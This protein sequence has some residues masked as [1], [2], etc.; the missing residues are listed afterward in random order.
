MLRVKK[1]QWK[2]CVFEHKLTSNQSNRIDVINVDNQMSHFYHFVEI[3]VE[4]I[5]NWFVLR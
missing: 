4:K 3:D 1:N 2:A 5:I